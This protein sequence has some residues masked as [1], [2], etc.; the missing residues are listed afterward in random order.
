MSAALSPRLPRKIKKTEGSTP[1]GSG[2]RVRARFKGRSGDELGAIPT[3]Y[4]ASFR[5]KPRLQ[6]GRSQPSILC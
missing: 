1:R 2:R 6:A 5:R 4:S 3:V